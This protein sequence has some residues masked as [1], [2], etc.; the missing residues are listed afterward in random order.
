MLGSDWLR[1]VYFSRI[2]GRHKNHIHQPS[3]MVLTLVLWG[4]MM[5]RISLKGIFIAAFG[6]TVSMPLTEGYCSRLPRAVT[7][8]NQA[9][10]QHIAR[11]FGKYP[12]RIHYNNCIHYHNTITTVHT[13]QRT[14]SN[15]RL[16]HFALSFFVNFFQLYF[17]IHNIYLINTSWGSSSRAGRHLQWSL[18]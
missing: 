7:S 4:F 18:L 1:G 5:K 13:T 14:I 6:K 17:F 16:W 2:F 10:K 8:S 3:K 9:L 11:P 12:S 15:K